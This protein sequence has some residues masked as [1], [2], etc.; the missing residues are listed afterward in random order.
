MTNCMKGLCNITILSE[1]PAQ[2]YNEDT[3]N[4][5]YTEVDGFLK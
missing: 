5:V 1:M 4:Q 2:V 3:V